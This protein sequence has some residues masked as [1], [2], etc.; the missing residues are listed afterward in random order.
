M[1]AATVHR[2]AVASLPG[3]TPVSANAMLRPN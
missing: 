2:S 1:L 3:R